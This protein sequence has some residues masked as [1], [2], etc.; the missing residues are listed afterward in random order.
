MEKNN[1]RLFCWEQVS[2]THRDFR[3]SQ[4]FATRQ[5][6]E[7]LLPLYAL[8]SVVEQI[9]STVSDEEVA[10]AKINWWRMECLQKKPGDSRH[11]VV[12]Q[13]NLT[14]AM[15]DMP[16]GSVSQLL[17]G[18]ESRLDSPA[19][20]DL[21]GLRKRCVEFQQPQLKMEM[22]VC[23]LERDSTRVGSQVLARNGLLQLIRES[24]GRK[25][26]GGYWWVPLNL[27]A[28]HDLSRSDLSDH[29]KSA[30]VAKLM[31]SVVS[32]DEFWDDEPV[33]SVTANSG[34]YLSMRNFFA[35][36]ELYRRKLQRLNGLTPERFTPVLARTGLTDLFTAWKSARRL[37]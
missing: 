10:R 19:P 35:I 16:M 31:A 20:S 2:R 12:Q 26:Q 17:D 6:A 23:G 24:E 34:E 28:R 29:S 8:F 25:E 21:Q 22:A 30:A 14:G 4:V 32:A 9:C 1:D 36:S 33:G 13:L 5:T 3:I 7:K 11:P 18:A 27:L 15:N 37:R